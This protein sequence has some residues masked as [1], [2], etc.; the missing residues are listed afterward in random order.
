M[1]PAILRSPVIGAIPTFNDFPLNDGFLGDR[2]GRRP[3]PRREVPV[4]TFFY[5]LE[6]EAR[7]L[8]E[9]IRAE[10]T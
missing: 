3:A 8:A 9:L 6:D 7:I 1:G 10:L 5:V 4:S 2:R